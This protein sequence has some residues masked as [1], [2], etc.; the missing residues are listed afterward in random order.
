MPRPLLLPL[1]LLLLLLFCLSF[2]QGI[3]CQIAS[4]YP[5]ICHN[6][7]NGEIPMSAHPVQTRKQ[8]F[9]E[10]AAGPL[11]SGNLCKLPPD[12]HFLKLTHLECIFNHLRAF[13]SARSR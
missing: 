8:I 1:L 9:Q 7:P 13:A 4:N 5:P 12:A 6:T 11:L 3:C 10:V 2:P